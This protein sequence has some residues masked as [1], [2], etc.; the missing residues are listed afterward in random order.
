[1]KNV[2]I[3]GAVNGVGKA[4]ANLL[5]EEN[6]ILI[7]IDKNNLPETAKE[8]NSEYYLCDLT[9]VDKINEIIM[10]KSIFPTMQKQGYGQIININSQS[11]LCVNHLSLFI[12]QQN[13]VYM[14]LEKQ[15][16]MI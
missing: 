12:M 7:D 16:K 9:N 14:L 4:V 2:I 13:I 3:T 5:K 15:Y 1:M 10:I 8:T 6:L 11:G